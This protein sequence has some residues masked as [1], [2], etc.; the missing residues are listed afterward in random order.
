MSDKPQPSD[1]LVSQ[2]PELWSDDH[3]VPFGTLVDSPN[4][5]CDAQG[6]IRAVSDSVLDKFGLPADEVIDQHI[7]SV[8]PSGKVLLRH[9]ISDSSHQIRTGSDESQHVSITSKTLNETVNGDEYTILY[10][11]PELSS[12]SVY[13]DS[14]ATGPQTIRSISDI[15]NNISDAVMLVDVEGDQILWGNATAATMLGYTQ[16]ELRNL[17]PSDIHPHDTEQFYQFITQVKSQGRTT[18]SNMH[19]QTAGGELL[20]V[21]VTGSLVDVANSTVLLTSIRNISKRIAKA[22]EL[23]K[24]A[25]AVDTA[26]DGIA[27]ISEGGT[28]QYANN[29]YAR[30]FDESTGDSITGSSWAAV[31][32]DSN[33]FELDIK[34][35]IDSEGSWQGELTAPSTEETDRIVSLSISTIESGEFVSLARDITVDRTHQ[36]RLSQLTSTNRY[37]MDAVSTDETAEITI[38]TLTEIF[39]FEIVAIREFDPESNSLTIRVATDRAETLLD[40]EPA[41]DLHASNA[42]QAYRSESTVRNEPLELDDYSEKTPYADLHIPLPGYGVISIIN[43]TGA[44][45]DR[46]VRLLEMFAESVLTAFSRA[47]RENQLRENN[48]ELAVANNINSIVT[49]IIRSVMQASSRQEVEYQVVTQLA[50]ADLYDVVWIANDRPQTT[51]EIRTVAGSVD[52][53]TE[54]EIEEFVQS[55]YAKDLILDAAKSSNPTI[56]YR[57]FDTEDPVHTKSTCSVATQIRCGS[58]SFGVLAVTLAPDTE[59]GETIRSALALLGE[60]LGF[61]LIADRRRKTLMTRGNIELEIAYR[62]PFGTLSGQYECVCNHLGPIEQPSPATNKYQVEITGEVPDNVESLLLTNDSI[63]ECEVDQI[64]D[65]KAIVTV[66]VRYPPPELLADMGVSLKSIIAQ[67]GEERLIAEAPAGIDPA[68]VLDAIATRWDDVRL[69]AKRSTSHALDAVITDNVDGLTDR[70]KSVLEAAISLG[71]YEWP[72]GS[73]AE[74]IA[75]TLDIASSTFHQHLRAAESKIMAQLELD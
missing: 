29:A 53:L 2:M 35:T 28:I 14:S 46:T 1:D 74:E 36:K 25:K 39:S 16:S 73:T 49:N 60:A 64:T 55:P 75:D 42:G 57:R 19:C 9:D 12:Q 27:I 44:F 50:N 5:L 61:A 59:F 54:S 45:D 30:L 31:H 69:V 68:T 15:V 43:P 62:G 8:I 52:S 24:L 47:H 65:S 10:I 51:Y 33:R 56:K 13:A 4:I 23:Q 21:E 22:E 67:E 70:Q 7:T 66:A 58:Q 72:R 26:T 20:P 41:Y 11:R 3:A 32:N 17:G 63:I 71:Y 40:T 34:P 6:S 18:S 48:A 37:L 38:Q